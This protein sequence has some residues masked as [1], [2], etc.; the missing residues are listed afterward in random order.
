MIR[1]LVNCDDL[2]MHP[3]INGAIVDLLSHDRVR[4]ASLLATGA[5]FD[6]AVRRLREVGRTAVGVHLALGNEYPQLR[7]RPVSPK[8]L[9]A[10]FVTNDGFLWPTWLG[11]TPIVDVDDAANELR[12]QVERV[13]AAGFSITHLDG[14]LFFY[15]PFEYGSN[16]LLDRVETM[17][18][19]I[20]V[21]FRSVAEPARGPVE[22]THFIWDGFDTAEARWG[23]YAGLLTTLKPG[24]H[25]LIV[26][27][28]DDIDAMSG[29]TRAASRR[30][31]DYEFLRSERFP[32]LLE[33]LR[34]DLVS[35]SEL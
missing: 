23:Y 6:D 8:S 16:E 17:A 2:G 11:K 29:F 27:P 7:T 22:Q 24:T 18:K 1:L 4:S 15:E 13:S 9:R 19:A 33:H 20:G 3:S 35:W 21:P 14:H 25:E 28:G 5:H 34:I 26:H 32:E 30:W 10:S 12:A 31:A